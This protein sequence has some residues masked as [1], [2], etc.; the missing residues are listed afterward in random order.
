MDEKRL[1]EWIQTYPKGIKFWPLDPR[2]E[3]IHI[4]DIAHALSNVCRFGGFV[5]HHYSVAQHSLLVSY[6]VPPCDALWAL[7]HDAP[8]AYLGDQCRPVKRSMVFHINECF[9]P[10]A[11]VEEELM[12]VV[13][14]R[15]GLEGSE[16]PPSVHEADL[17]MLMTEK[18]DLLINGGLVWGEAQGIAQPYDDLT[19]SEMTTEGVCWN[20]LKRFDKLKGDLAN[21]LQM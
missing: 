15:F 12:R 18:R 16:I 19:I 6:K 2:P 13:A 20:F 14:K 5:K 10:F 4:E 11:K 3:E 17:R 1:G 9:H 21:G 7:L 8:E